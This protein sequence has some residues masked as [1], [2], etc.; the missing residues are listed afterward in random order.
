[1]VYDYITTK[2]P[3]D[4]ETLMH[5]GVKGMKWG[6]RKQQLISKG[7]SKRDAGKQVRLE[8]K[9]DRLLNTSENWQKDYDARRL[10]KF[11]KKKNRYSK[12]L[13][14]YGKKH[15]KDEVKLRRD[16]YNKNLN[17]FDQQ[18]KDARVAGKQHTKIINNYYKQ[19][20]G[21]ISNKNVKK[22]G[23]YKDAKKLYKDQRYL[24]VRYGAWGGQPNASIGKYMLEAERDRK[25]KTGSITKNK[26]RYV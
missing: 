26:K 18:T 2:P 6:Q 9:R 19:K 17:E 1:M 4:E 15:T 22:T 12:K 5:Y 24:D 13:E 11:E 3:L 7:M 16:K 25:R 10:R 20:I 14:K 8:K 21:S 23:E